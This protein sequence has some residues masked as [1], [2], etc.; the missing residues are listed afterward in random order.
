ME[1][2]RLGRNLTEKWRRGSLH[3]GEQ[4]RS[5]VQKAPGSSSLGGGGQS[6]SK[7]QGLPQRMTF[8]FQNSHS[9]MSSEQNYYSIITLFTSVTGLGMNLLH[10]EAIFLSKC[11]NFYLRKS[12][13]HKILVSSQLHR[14]PSLTAEAYPYLGIQQ[15]AGLDASAFPLRLH[16]SNDLSPTCDL[17]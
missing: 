11:K 7:D 1:T 2:I 10:F 3:P 17:S 6:R 4:K 5:Q 12:S 8:L 15:R 14:K 9:A 16:Y 13:F